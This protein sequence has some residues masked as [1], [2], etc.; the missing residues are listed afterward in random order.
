M[1]LQI[2]KKALKPESTFTIILNANIKTIFNIER[3]IE[4]KTMSIRWSFFSTTIAAAIE[5]DKIN[6][7]GIG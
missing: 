1:Q 6:K 7:N 2:M 4:E 5:D 3:M